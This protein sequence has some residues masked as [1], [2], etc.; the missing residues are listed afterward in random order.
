M[1]IVHVFG[2]WEKTGIPGENIQNS[3]QKAPANRWSLTQRILALKKSLCHPICNK[4]VL[5]ILQKF[6]TCILKLC[7]LK[8][9][10]VLEHRS[11][12]AKMNESYSYQ[13]ILLSI[14]CFSL[15]ES[16]VNGEM[17]QN[18]LVSL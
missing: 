11:F 1:C 14:L 6:R 4:N 16:V 8:N 13:F 15:P 10:C 5:K 12:I 2:P 3:I 7:L 17:H 18:C 9:R